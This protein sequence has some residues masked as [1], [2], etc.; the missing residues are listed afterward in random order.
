MLVDLPVGE[1]RGVFIEVDVRWLVAWPSSCGIGIDGRR[2]DSF[3]G[4]GEIPGGRRLLC[5]LQRRSVSDGD[6]PPTWG[7]AGEDPDCLLQELSH[8][9]DA[10]GL[11]EPAD[12]LVDPA[13][14]S[15]LA[16]P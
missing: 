12:P 3:E 9:G 6:V 14:S 11:G 8:P 1:M 13:P 16:A 10:H 7:M 5:L 2:R 4:Q 15:A